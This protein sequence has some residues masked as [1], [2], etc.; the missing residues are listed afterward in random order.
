MRYEYNYDG[1]LGMN[2]FH[3]R[4]VAKE[5]GVSMLVLNNS[6]KSNRV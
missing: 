4:L 1:F 2:F 6:A 3:V 5:E